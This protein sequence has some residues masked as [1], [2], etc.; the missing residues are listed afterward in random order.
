MDQ[1]QNTALNIKSGTTGFPKKWSERLAFGTL[2][3]FANRFTVSVCQMCPAYPTSS[4][5]VIFFEYIPVWL[6]LYPTLLG[7]RQSHLVVPIFPC[8]DG[9][10]NSISKLRYPAISTGLEIS[11]CIAKTNILNYPSKFHQFI[12]I[13]IYIHICILPNFVEIFMVKSKLAD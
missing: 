4:R 2:D 3:S 7:M 6:V 8:V 9:D 11:P 1:K 5:L 10:W 12:C 13:Y